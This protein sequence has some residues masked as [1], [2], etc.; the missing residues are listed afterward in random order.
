MRKILI[1]SDNKNEARRI[2]S[3]LKNNNHN[4][5]FVADG[6]LDG[7]KKISNWRP[8]LVI[9]EILM[10]EMNA[11]EIVPFIKTMNQDMKVIAMT[12]GGIIEADDY[13]NAIK[14]LGADM[15]IKKPYRDKFLINSV[16][17]LLNQKLNDYS[18]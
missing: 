5:I 1:I 16:R 14:A 9:T 6:G 8:D 17:T 15:V 3:V 4:S 2:K 10:K 7:K 18:F 11:F 13:L 12:L